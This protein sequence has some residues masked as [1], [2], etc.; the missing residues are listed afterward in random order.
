MSAD[1]KSYRGIVTMRDRIFALAFALTALLLA[2]LYELGARPPVAL[3]LAVGVITVAAVAIRL[4]T[5]G[6]PFLPAY[7]LVLYS[8]PFAN[9]VVHAVNPPEYFLTQDLIWS[10]AANDYQRMPSII[11]AVGLV[12]ATGATALAAGMFFIAAIRKAEPARP[13]EV[14]PLPLPG[15]LLLAAAAIG[16]GW[17]QAPSTTM[18]DVAYPGG[19]S[20]LQS[21]G[22][23]FNAAV[24]MAGLLISAAVINLLAD[25]GPTRTIQAILVA[26]AIF[27]VTFW[28]QFLRGHRETA[29]IFPALFVLA[30]FEPSLARALRRP[31]AWMGVIAG[32]LT[33]LL[34]LQVIA[35]VR[36]D[37]GTTTTPNDEGCPI[38]NAWAA[39]TGGVQQSSPVR[40]TEEDA[41]ARRGRDPTEVLTGIPG[42]INVFGGTW[43]A[44]LLTPLSVVGDAE[45][46]LLAPRM[47]RTYVDYVLS[48]PPSFVAQAFGYER[49]IEATH[50]PAWQMRF[51]IGGTH[52]VVVPFMDFRA[53]G[54]AVILFLF[55][56]LVALTESAARSRPTWGRLLWYA[57]ALIV[58]PSWVWYG[59]L[60]L[61]RAAMAAV[62]VW[63]LIWALVNVGPWIA[64]LL[65]SG[66]ASRSSR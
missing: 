24:L 56:A 54:V 6:F 59:D 28:Y 27:L 53:P 62:A 16:F 65:R 36:S 60:Y 38:V 45:R 11:A 4:R 17:I 63:A 8:I 20:P 29:V 46:G 26:V 30:T 19:V 34:L 10:L 18:F 37:I 42:R 21:C 3:S 32:V 1:P 25:R 35:A 23:E 57:A 51:G 58:A 66:V 64:L 13:M 41:D 9:L 12:G 40:E 50:G 2:A 15:V 52:L 22:I 47:G 43:S 39:I 14:R 55:G 61:A 49:P 7:V 31:R 5:P 33:L 44:A 48:L